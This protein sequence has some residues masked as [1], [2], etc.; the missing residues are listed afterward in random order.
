VLLASFLSHTGAFAIGA[1][2]SALIALCFLWRGGPALR[3]PAAAV[4]AATA[5]GM[6]GAIVLYYAHFLETYRTEMT[7]IG[8]ETVANAPDAGQRGIGDRLAAVPRYLVLYY[9]VPMMVL[10][11]SGAVLLWRRGARDRVTLTCGGW[12]AGCLVFWIAGILTPVDMRHYLASIPAV[13]A[14]GAVGATIAW[15][16]A[17]QRAAVMTLLGW[18]VYV[19]VHAWWTTLQ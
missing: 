15:T 2:G 3:S 11:A 14:F 18:T 5:L 4:V 16:G 19:G 17:R 6:V 10:W 1:L 8:T 9:G 13:A 12:L 7:R